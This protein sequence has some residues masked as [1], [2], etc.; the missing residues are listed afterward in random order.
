MLE[1]DSAIIVPVP[2]LIPNLQ[3]DDEL[4]EQLKFVGISISLASQH[5]K[6]K[7]KSHL[8]KC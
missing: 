5:S 2:D 6:F 3:L 1:E 4:Q 8:G 7:G